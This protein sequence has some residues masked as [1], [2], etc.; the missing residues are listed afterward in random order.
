[1]RYVVHGDKVFP[2]GI[3][4]DPD[5]R[6]FYVSGSADGTIYRGERGVPDTEVW[7]EAG[8]DGR[9]CALGMAADPYGRL[10]V[11]GGK[12][13]VLYAYD[14]ATGAL[15]AR[16]AVG[17]EPTLLND[18]CVLGDHAYVTDSLRPVVWRFGL[19]ADGVGEAEEL[20]GL[21][22][23]DPGDAYL[24]GIVPT[25]DGDGLLVAAQGT[26]ELWRVE[27]ATRTA[28]R[29]DLGGVPVNGDGMVWVGDVLYVCD[30]TDEPDGSVRYWLTALRLDGTHRAVLAGRWEQRPEDTP[31]T[32]A[33]VGGRLLLVH[34]QFAMRRL[35]RPVEPPF[36]VGELD[37][38]L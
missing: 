23:H 15:V 34:S 1:M 17:T 4:E 10:L 38:P 20:V 7:Q 36:T 14:L 8:S 37:P 33:H 32:V 25:P 29:V 19:G 24:N 28:S 26:G 27:V 18:V 9:D 31:T 16:R 30:N 35:G 12:D 6:G 22:S 11:C 2:E 5:G 21:T 3:T 13:G